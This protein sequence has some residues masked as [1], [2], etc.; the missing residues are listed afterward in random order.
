MAALRILVVEDEPD[1]ADV[2]RRTLTAAGIETDFA[3]TA[4]R[5]LTI[6]DDTPDAF[7]AALIDLALPEMDGFELME[8]LRQHP[9]VSELVLVAM[10]AFHT[11]ELRERALQ[12]GFDAYF[13]KPLDTMFMLQTLEKLV[14]G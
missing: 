8:R 2:I 7:D 12:A 6:L 13:A 11:A 3:P 1:G 9:D 5:A 14:S 10:T 4:E